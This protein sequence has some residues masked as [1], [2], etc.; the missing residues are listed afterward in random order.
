MRFVVHHPLLRAIAGSTAT[1][2][3]FN[4]M[5]FALYVLFAIRI[6]GLAPAS[7]GLIFGLG[8]VASLAGAVYAGQ[9]ASR[10]GIGRVIMGAQALGVRIIAPEFLAPARAAGAS[11]AG[12]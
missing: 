8:S 6:L 12:T 10:F 4:A 1:G 9:L 2:N 7:I 3:F 11:G 5:L